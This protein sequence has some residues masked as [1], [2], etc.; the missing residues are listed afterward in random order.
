MSRS[1]RTTAAREKARAFAEREAQL[2]TIAEEFF[3]L[4]ENTPAAKIDNEIAALEK[5]LEALR[6][7]REE[8]R[9]ELF[10]GPVK[11]H[12]KEY[13]LQDRRGVFNADAVQGS[14]R[15]CLPITFQVREAP[16]K[17]AA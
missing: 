17:L 5:K 10:L 7:K 15:H 8:A 4:Q 1:P 16:L 6:A 3:T 14:S 11:S 2:L 12:R 13:P 9:W